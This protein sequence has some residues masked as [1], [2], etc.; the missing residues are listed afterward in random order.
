MLEED[1]AAKNVTTLACYSPV[2]SANAAARIKNAAARIK[3]I[4]GA[5]STKPTPLVK[6]KKT[7]LRPKMNLEEFGRMNHEERC[8]QIAY[9]NARFQVINVCDSYIKYFEI[10]SHAESEPE[11][12][13]LWTADDDVDADE[14]WKRMITMVWLSK[15]S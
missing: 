8:A 14:K 10:S 1:D 5:R 9:V 3:D 15:R 11:E 13:K 4:I 12:L 7:L 6:A 2:R